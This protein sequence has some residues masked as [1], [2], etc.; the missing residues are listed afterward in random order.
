MRLRY[1]L[2]ATMV[3]GCSLDLLA[4]GCEPG[5]PPKAPCATSIV[6]LYTA[7]M[8]AAGCTGEHFSDPQ[9]A[10]IKERRD[11]REHEAGCTP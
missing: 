2:A 7:E 1:V 11:M 4:L 6:A 3:L 9:C 8:I 5:S 10:P